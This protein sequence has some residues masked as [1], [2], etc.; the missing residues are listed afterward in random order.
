MKP[1]IF[2]V[3]QQSAAKLAFLSIDFD[4]VRCE[5]MRTRSVPLF[6]FKR[7]WQCDVSNQQIIFEKSCKLPLIAF[8]VHKNMFV[9]SLLLRG[10]QDDH[11]MYTHIETYPVWPKWLPLAALFAI[12]LHAVVE[13]GQREKIKIFFE[14]EIA[15]M[16]ASVA[17]VVSAKKRANQEWR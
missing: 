8:H 6:C 3:E 9:R 7:L 14:K 13:I 15:D 4:S 17:A 5:A 2:A 16:L 11:P 12:G 10:I 1:R